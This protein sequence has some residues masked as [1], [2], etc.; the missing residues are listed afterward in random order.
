MRFIELSRWRLTAA[1]ILSLPA[2]V[3][4][5]DLSGAPPD[6]LPVVTN[7][8]QEGAQLEAH[9][10]M[11]G[12]YSLEDAVAGAFLRTASINL[13]YHDINDNLPTPLESPNYPDWPD[14]FTYGWVYQDFTNTYHDA[15]NYPWVIF[16]VNH[17]HSN[18]TNQCVPILAGSSNPSP[19][20]NVAQ[21]DPTQRNSF[22]FVTDIKLREQTLCTNPA[23]TDQQ[24]ETELIHV[25]THEFGHQRA[26]LTDDN[27][28]NQSLYHN[29]FVPSNREDV[30]ASPGSYTEL[31]G[32]S[33]P[34]FDA[35]GVESSG[36]HSTCRGNLITNQSVH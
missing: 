35:T 21:S 34:V 29:G 28:T 26:G 33:D 19:S 30:M 1:V 10:D 8:V 16:Y 20:P 17:Y 13:G 32:H 12:M 25:V 23:A 11:A 22:I 6:Q 5:Q 31:W 2:A 3:G 9:Q 36:D 14:D 15:T 7:A 27:S 24:L 18:S 4:C